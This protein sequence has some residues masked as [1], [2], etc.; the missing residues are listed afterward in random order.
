MIFCNS[1]I[2]S[3]AYNL[4]TIILPFTKAFCCARSALVL[5]KKYKASYEEH[6]LLHSK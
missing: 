5:L 2:E 4:I 3:F 1:Q 6:G